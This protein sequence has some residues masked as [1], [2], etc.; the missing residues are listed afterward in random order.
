MV[1]R[2]NVASGSMPA[3]IV[4]SSTFPVNVTYPEAGLNPQDVSVQSSGKVNSVVFD[5]GVSA[6]IGIVMI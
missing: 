5:G 4:V 6:L 3:I 2:D 1:L